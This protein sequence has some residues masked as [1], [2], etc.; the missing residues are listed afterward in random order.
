MK[1]EDIKWIEG[2]YNSDVSNKKL[3]AAT[4][5]VYPNVYAHYFK[6]DIVLDKQLFDTLKKMYPN[7][8]VQSRIEYF[9]RSTPCANYMPIRVPIME[10]LQG[11]QITIYDYKLIIAIT[12]QSLYIYYTNQNIQVHIDDLLKVFQRKNELKVAQVKLIAYSNGFYTIDSK[13]NVTDINLFENYND[14]FMPAYDNI[15]NFLDERKSGLVIIRGEKGTGK[16]NLLRHLMTTHPDNY[17]IVTNATASYLAAPGFMTFMMEHQNSVF[18]LEDCE[19]ILMDRSE[20]FNN[21]IATILNMSDGLLSD[22]FNVKFICTFNADIN[23]IDEALLRKG[24][25][26]VNYEFTKLSAD[27]TKVLLNKQGIELDKYEP[28]TLADIYNYEA[29]ECVKEDKKKIGF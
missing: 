27:K 29:P 10:N 4:F 26:F 25:C 19:Q 13:I 16:T 1:T 14:D 28:M 23:K 17:I 21:T 22:I 6:Q 3:F 12:D 24:R 9:E 20:S 8:V 15:I 7:A 18:V 2:F 5:G 11:S